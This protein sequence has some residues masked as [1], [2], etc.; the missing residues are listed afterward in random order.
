[1][2]AVQVPCSLWYLQASPHETQ[3]SFSIMIPSHSCELTAAIALRELGYRLERSLTRK[4][5][6]KAEDESTAT[7]SVS[8]FE[9]V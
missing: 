4:T 5:K 6:H 7:N 3:L 8:E 9:S 2:V 1:M